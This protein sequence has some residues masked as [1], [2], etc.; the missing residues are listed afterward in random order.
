ML[1]LNTNTPLGAWLCL[2]TP[3]H[4]R[5]KNVLYAIV[6]V[7]YFDHVLRPDDGL[8]RLIEMQFADNGHQ[9]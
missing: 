8:K 3:H 5:P 6:I 7:V 1:D 9:Y 2:L 4:A